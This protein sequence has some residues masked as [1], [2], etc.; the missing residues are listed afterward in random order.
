MRTM[1]CRTLVTKPADL[2]S[3]IG[4]QS[5]QV[6]ATVNDSRATKGTPSVPSARFTR[7]SSIASRTRNASS[8]N[9]TMFS[10]VEST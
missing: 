6:L 1:V 5:T 10:G 9:L 2:C 8:R 3:T 7:E 4:I